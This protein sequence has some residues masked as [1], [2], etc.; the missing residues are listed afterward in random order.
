MRAHPYAGPS[1][2]ADMGVERGNLAWHITSFD[3]ARATRAWGVSNRV[4]ILL[5]P[6]GRFA[7]SR[8]WSNFADLNT[9][10]QVWETNILPQ[11][12]WRLFW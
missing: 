8:E 3:A 7:D 4:I 12:R 5:T 9:C 2:S 6:V 10:L 11:P 1:S